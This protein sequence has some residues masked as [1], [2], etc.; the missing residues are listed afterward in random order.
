MF[1]FVFVFVFFGGTYMRLK[2]DAFYF[3]G[4]IKK[5]LFRYQPRV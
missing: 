2:F 1:F 3:L 4:E 5:K